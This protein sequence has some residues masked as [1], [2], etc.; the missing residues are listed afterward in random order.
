MK[1]NEKET[2]LLLLRLK[3]RKQIVQG[4][5]SIFVGR[6]V[7]SCLEAGHVPYVLGPCLWFLLSSN[8][9]MEGIRNGAGPGKVPRQRHAAFVEKPLLLRFNHVVGPLPW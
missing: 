2:R 9:G 6:F 7:V 4:S 3:N 8:P 1:R 5:T